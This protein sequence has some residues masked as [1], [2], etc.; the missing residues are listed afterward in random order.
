M[1]SVAG[2]TTTPNVLYD[3]MG[4]ITGSDTIDSTT[5]LDWDAVYCNANGHMVCRLSGDTTAD[6][7]FT[8]CKQGTIYL[9]KVRY[10]KATGTT[11]TFVGLK[12]Q[13]GIREDQLG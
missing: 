1:G 6:A 4:A 13:E 2:Y 3:Q 10:V 9:L 5:L 8:N 11:G 12:S 7:T